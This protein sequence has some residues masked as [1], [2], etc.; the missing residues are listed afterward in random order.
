MYGRLTSSV[1]SSSMT[2]RICV[3]LSAFVGPD[4][5]EADDIR[6]SSGNEIYAWQPYPGR[7]PPQHR[8]LTSHGT[9]CTCCGCQSGNRNGSRYQNS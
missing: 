6:E 9:P 1:F 3:I 7:E 4:R 2:L 8:F 5:E